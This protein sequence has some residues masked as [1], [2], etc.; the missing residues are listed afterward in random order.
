MEQFPKFLASRLAR[1]QQTAEAHPDA[2]ALTA[3]AE[4][5]LKPAERKPLLPHLPI[6]ADSPEVMALV[7]SDAPERVESPNNAF[8]L[9]SLRWAAALAV[10]C[11]VTVVVV[12]HPVSV[13]RSGIKSERSNVPVAATSPTS[14]DFATLA[15]TPGK[16]K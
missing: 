11:L 4:N 3:F 10:A 6:C 12:R 14:P 8:N 7:S 15:R 9:W 16:E 5:R 13:Q 2:N 1:Q